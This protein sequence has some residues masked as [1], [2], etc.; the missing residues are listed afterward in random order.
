MAFTWKSN[1]VGLDKSHF[2]MNIKGLYLCSSAEAVSVIARDCDRTRS[3]QKV[4]SPWP[5]TE[6]QTHRETAS[7][8]H[9][10]LCHSQTATVWRNAD[11]VF[12]RLLKMFHVHDAILSLFDDVL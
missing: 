3:V 4:N 12:F 7:T 5:D 10:S 8:I 11:M 6:I 1:I 2:L 9:Q